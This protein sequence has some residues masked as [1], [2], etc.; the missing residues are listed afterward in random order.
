[1]LMETSKKLSIP[2][3]QN[4]IGVS[5]EPS[6][7]AYLT[8]SNRQILYHVPDRMKVRGELLKIARNYMHEVIGTSCTIDIFENIIAA[9]HQA[10]WHHCGIWIKNLAVSKFAKAVGSGGLHL[11]LD[12]D[13]CDTAMLL[14]GQDEN[15]NW[16]FQRI[17]IESKQK[18]VPLELRSLPQKEYIK[19][20][21]NAVT[22]A[23]P[24]Q[25]CNSIWSQPSIIADEKISNLR[26]VADLI[27]YLQSV[28]NISLGFDNI[29][30]LPASLLS[31]S[32]AFLDFVISL[33]V[34]ARD[35]AD[36][37]NNG[38]DKTL[39]LGKSKTTIG[40]RRLVYERQKDLTELPFWL[41]WPDGNRTS[42]Y[43]H[44]N[45]SG[46]IWISNGT[47]IIGC[48]HSQSKSGKIDQLRSMLQQ[49][50]IRLRP[51]AISLTLF[52]RLFLT[53]WFVHGVGAQ[54]YETVTNYI[55]ENYY[56]VKPPEFGIATCTMRLPLSDDVALGDDVLQ[57][58]QKMRDIRHNPEKYIDNS[59]LKNQQVEILV[60]T[61]RQLIEL[62]ADR[63]MSS[64][65]RKSA[66]KSLGLTNQRLL[67]YTKNVTSELKS[68]AI[69]SQK[70]KVSHQVCSSR[71]YFFGLFPKQKLNEITNSFTF[72]GS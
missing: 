61:K 3:K 41:V 25:F 44:S 23:Y 39:K 46:A 22:K 50:G 10:V 31:E 51:K 21:L 28:L 40:I 48:L 54:M 11:V 26:N 59:K 49:A 29:L 7:W 55:I 63:S 66:W 34:N 6:Q 56:K 5:P 37:Y 33:T 19:D 30:Y 45:E 27:T 72:P 16:F 62:A 68:K 36:C 9:G 60:K 69:E 70:N 24:W 57:L 52:A 8:A 14:P 2:E 58:R 13:I 71:E 67:E 47:A 1:M 43:V 35:F 42:L 38:I 20:F 64:D 18:S 15:C 4:V 17:E 65:K 12:H 53:D 32:D